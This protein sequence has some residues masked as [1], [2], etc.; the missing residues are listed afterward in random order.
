MVQQ[1]VTLNEIRLDDVRLMNREGAE[2]AIRYFKGVNPHLPEV[3]H[4]KPRLGEPVMIIIF[5]EMT[6]IIVTAVETSN[7]TGE[8]VFTLIASR[9]LSYQMGL[10]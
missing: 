7:L 9:M 3:N 10:S 4:E 5:W 1:L 2:P 6:I 8:P